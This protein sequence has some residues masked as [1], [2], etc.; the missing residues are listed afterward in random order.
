[1]GLVPGEILH[2][3]PYKIQLIDVFEDGT[4]AV[5]AVFRP[6]LLQKQGSTQLIPTEAYLEAKQLAIAWEHKS[7][8]E[9]VQVVFKH[10]FD[11]VSEMRR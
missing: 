2:V 11:P 3:G 1:M 7:P 6:S 8:K 5:R 10:G 9:R 4:V